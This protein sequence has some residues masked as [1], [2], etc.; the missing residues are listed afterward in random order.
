[1]LLAV[2]IMDKAMIL[3]AVADYCLGELVT[4]AITALIVTLLL[5]GNQVVVLI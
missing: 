5:I 3:E 4:L 2:T 1:M